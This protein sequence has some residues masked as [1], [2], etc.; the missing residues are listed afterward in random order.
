[1]S[2]PASPLQKPGGRRE[3]KKLTCVCSGN[4]FCDHFQN[5]TTTAS[6]ECCKLDF[7]CFLFSSLRNK[8]TTSHSQDWSITVHW[9]VLILRFHCMCM[10]Y[11]GIHFFVCVCDNIIPKFLPFFFVLKNWI[12]VL[13]FAYVN[14][15]S[16]AHAARKL[17]HPSHTKP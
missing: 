7:Q 12:M 14:L 2:V 5:K 9:V 4:L 6:Q 13:L 15:T 17:G 3:Q 1:M 11:T 8:T 16:I 10:D